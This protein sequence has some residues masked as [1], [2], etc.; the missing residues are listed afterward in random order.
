MKDGLEGLFDAAFAPLGDAA[1]AVDQQGYLVACNAAFETLFEISLPTSGNIHLDQLYHGNDQTALA[2]DLTTAEPSK[3]PTYRQYRKG[4]GS[5]FW[6]EKSDAAIH[7]ASRAYLGQF[8]TIRDVTD[9]VALEEGLRSLVGLPATDLQQDSD[10]LT[11]LLELGC[12][13]LNAEHGS[14][15]RIEDGDY[16][17]E[18]VVGPC[19]RHQ[20]G[21][22]LPIAESVASLPY[23]QDGVLS[24]EQPPRTK[25]LKRACH[26]RS[27]FNVYLS[28]KVYVAGRLY[29]TLD[30]AHRSSAWAGLQE[31]QRLFLRVMAAWIGFLLEGQMTRGALGKATEDLERFVHIA[32]H[33]LQEPLRRVVSYCQILMEDFS[34]ELSN[35]AVE[36]VETVQTGGK[37]MRH[38]LKDLLEYSQL[39][40]QLAQAFEPVDMT[41]VVWQALDNLADTL[42]DRRLDIDV[43]TLPLVW[44]HA[45]LLQKVCYHLLDNSIK[46]A[47]QHTPRIDVA[48]Q[49]RGHYW[50]FSM[51]DRGIGIEPRF[52][53]QVFDIFQ[54]LHPRDDFS[55]TG[56]GLAI[57]KLIIEGYGGS[58]WLDPVY[59]EG[60]RFLFTLPKE[61]R[62]ANAVVGSVYPLSSHPPQQP[63]HGK[64]HKS[65]F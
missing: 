56:A 23:D 27:G 35:D 58:I 65:S 17:F 62:V 48:I 41:S 12:Q 36:V 54:R 3:T 37:R 10:T 25:I 39:N 57:C 49:D 5:I 31:H 51:A 53:D 4:N 44:G 63:F 34:T 46:F 64:N 59:E 32:T 13:H 55:G 21:D 14:L 20:A 33:D 42:G 26:D 40:Q 8:I 7:S 15:G 19:K 24:L 2:G 50:E 52:A 1:F 11:R 16:T 38:M 22:K 29:G 47:G 43:A 30:F 60:T 28:S 45:S 9:R 18:I 6:G 61:K